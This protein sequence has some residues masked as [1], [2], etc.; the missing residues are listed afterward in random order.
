MEK[1][2]TVKLSRQ[3]RKFLEKASVGDRKRLV[4]SLREMGDDPHD[5][6]VKLKGSP[7]SRRRVGR[8][9]IVFSVKNQELII[10]VVM[11]DDRKQ[12]YRDP[13]R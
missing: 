1:A 13:N 8:F 11:I 3:A 12:V 6:A 5:R 10:L 9:R 4:V 2:Y 7:Y